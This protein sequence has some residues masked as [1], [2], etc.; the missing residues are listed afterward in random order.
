MKTATDEE[1]ATMGR[2]VA[3]AVLKGETGERP[4]ADRERVPL[5]ALMYVADQHGISG[6]DPADYAKLAKGME[7]ALEE[8][9]RWND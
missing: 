9:A 2:E 6:L 4:A 7:E 8:A 3:S 1:L 5:V